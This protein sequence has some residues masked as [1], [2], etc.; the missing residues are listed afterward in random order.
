MQICFPTLDGRFPG[1][2]SSGTANVLKNS[3]F[4]S[5]QVARNTVAMLGAEQACPVGCGLLSS[6]LLLRKPVAIQKP[7]AIGFLQRE[8]P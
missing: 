1:L 3:E 7:I 5:V 6:V 2:G 4:W 8:M